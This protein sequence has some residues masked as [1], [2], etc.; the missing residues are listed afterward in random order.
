VNPELSMQNFEDGN[1]DVARFDHEAHIF[2]GWLYIGRHELPQAIIRFDSALKRLIRRSG[3][4]EKYHATITWLFLLLI[5]E[6]YR[7]NE[8][9]AAF[10]QRNQDLFLDSQAVL[11]K[12]YTTARLHSDPARARFLLPDRLAGQKSPSIRP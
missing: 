6:R 1:I 4:P 7:D 5:H 8:T 12:Y 3:A 9:F 10:R 2:I 11:G